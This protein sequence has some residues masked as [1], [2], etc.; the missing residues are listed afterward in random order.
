MAR[1]RYV[2]VKIPLELATTLD[3]LARSEAYRSRADIVND[4]IRRFIETR[5]LFEEE[6]PAPRR[7]KQLSLVTA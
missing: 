5:R 3:E 2:M 1:N 4:A 6:S 7:H